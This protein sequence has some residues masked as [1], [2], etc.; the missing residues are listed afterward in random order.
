MC[1]PYWEDL[2]GW[3]PPGLPLPLLEGTPHV[4]TGH[5]CTAWGKVSV[6][7]KD[8]GPINVTSKVQYGFWRQVEGRP[9]ANIRCDPKLLR[10]NNLQSIIF[11][12]RA[13]NWLW[14]TAAK[15]TAARAHEMCEDSVLL[16][17]HSW[18]LP[19]PSSC[20]IRTGEMQIVQLPLMCI[21]TLQRKAFTHLPH[22]LMRTTKVKPNLSQ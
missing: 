12:A 10:Q 16:E 6:S 15:G 14:D 9:P 17:W 19:L 22:L 3:R 4:S 18:A 20:I 2:S 21:T 13:Q 8:R 11:T 1:S 5:H 7:P